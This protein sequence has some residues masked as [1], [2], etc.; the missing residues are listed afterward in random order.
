MEFQWNIQSFKEF[1]DVTKQ[2]KL[3]VYGG[4]FNAMRFINRYLSDVKIEYIC[5]SSEQKQGQRLFGIPIEAPDKLKSENPGKTVVLVA[6]SFYDEIIKGIMR[7]GNFTCFISNALEAQSAPR[8]AGFANNLDKVNSVM[9]LF[10]DDRSRYVLSEI[11]KRAMLG[12]GNLTDLKEPYP[13][14]LANELFASS[15]PCKEEIIINGG[16][17]W[18]GSLRRFV[19]FFGEKLKKAYCFEPC[20]ELVE[21]LQSAASKITGIDIVIEPVGLSDENSRATFHFLPENPR[22]SFVNG[23]GKISVNTAGAASRI[24]D[25]KKLDDIIPSNEK[26]TFIKMDV[27]GSE[28]QALLGAKRIIQKDKPRLAICI[29]HNPEDFFQIPLLINSMVPEYKMYARHHHRGF[30]ETTLYAVCD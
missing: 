4:S 3:I 1:Y 21:K 27:E 29:Y 19:D 8:G 7:I 28:Y 5:D 20:L 11:I 22:A 17:C 25:L 18:G 10:A 24:V 2:K 26:I 13:Q 14:Y 9:P 15:P 16:A 6:S 12:D 23:K 30:N